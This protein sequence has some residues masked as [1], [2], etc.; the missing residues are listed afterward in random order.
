MKKKLSGLYHTH[1]SRIAQGLRVAVVICAA[2]GWWGFIY[3]DLTLLPETVEISE[4]GEDGSLRPLSGEG[5]DARGLYMELLDA[6]P[7]KI[8]FRS[9][10][11]TNLKLLWE[12][13]HEGN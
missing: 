12:N 5:K 2:L 9:R 4:E 7:E 13:L 1:S 3:P 6:D 10:V 8:V 11:L